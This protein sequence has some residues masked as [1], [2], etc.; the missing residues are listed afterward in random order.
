MID[1]KVLFSCL[2]FG[3]CGLVILGGQTPELGRFQLELYGGISYMNPQDLNLLFRAE[4]QYN[5]IYF[6]QQLRWMQGYMVNDFPRLNSVIPAGFRIKYRLSSV[7]ALSLGI[8][9]FTGQR[10]K[11]LEGSFSYSS[12]YSETVTK[13]YDPFKMEISGL[14]VLGGIHYRIPV[15][16]FT[17]LE[18]GAAVGWAKARFE[19]SS[20]WSHEID[21]ESSYYEY[22]SLDSGS[23]EGDGSGNGLMAQAMFRLNRMISRRLGIFLEAV[24]IFCRMSSIAGSGKETRSGM[25][26]DKT[27]EGEWGI[28]REEIEMAW[29]SATVSVPT[30]YWDGWQASQRERDFTLN[31]S[32]VRLVL[33]ICFRF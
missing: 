17:D 16:E 20:S 2:L 31:I 11:S 10:E 23:L 7:L 5:N 30:N 19:H 1:K 22:S 6:I 13:K 32:G 29:G 28:K 21:F 15:G 9:G 24:G 8:E 33:G 26:G 14:A 18:L 3:L 27:W 25:E 4:E 12:Y